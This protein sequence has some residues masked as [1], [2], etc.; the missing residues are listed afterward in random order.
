MLGPGLPKSEGRIEC[1]VLGSELTKPDGGNEGIV[2]NI[3]L[4]CE[5][6]TLLGLLDIKLGFKVAVGAWVG[7]V[8]E[9]LI[10]D[11]GSANDTLSKLTILGQTFS[12]SLLL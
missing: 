8:I 11:S 7:V 5:L 12:M 1:T 10:I 2:L 6:C 4:G 3:L 9:L